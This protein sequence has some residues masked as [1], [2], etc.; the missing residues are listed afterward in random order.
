MSVDDED[1]SEEHEDPESSEFEGDAGRLELQPLP[2]S[3]RVFGSAAL[4][5]GAFLLMIAGCETFGGQLAFLPR[6][7]YV[8]RT[9]WIGLGILL[10]PVGIA[11]QSQR[12]LRQ[13]IWRPTRLGRRFSRV[14]VYTRHGCHLCDVALGVLQDPQYQPYLPVP[15][16]VDIDA[17]VELRRRF[18]ELVP[19]VECDGKIRFTGRVDE[20]LLRRLIEGTLP[21]TLECHRPR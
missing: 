4:Y 10:I 8:N 15:E 19:V 6:F 16:E 17:D 14:R 18:G 9:L 1:D 21:S 11:I 2:L 20:V 12:P 3:N 5:L 13:V 7:W